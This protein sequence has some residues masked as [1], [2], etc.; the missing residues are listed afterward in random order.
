MGD[1]I[2]E[3]QTRLDQYAA[4]Q[5]AWALLRRRGIQESMERIFNMLTTLSDGISVDFEALTKALREAEE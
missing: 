2:A 5:W 1:I 4:L 3:G